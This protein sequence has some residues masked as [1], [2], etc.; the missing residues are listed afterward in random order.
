M[1]ARF[2]DQ[3]GTSLHGTTRRLRWTDIVDVF[4]LKYPQVRVS[5]CLDGVPVVFLVWR[6]AHGVY[7]IQLFDSKKHAYAEVEIRGLQHRAGRV[8]AKEFADEFAKGGSRLR[9]NKRIAELEVE[10]PQFVTF[11]DIPGF[12]NILNWGLFGYDCKWGAGE[13]C[14]TGSGMSVNFVQEFVL[15]EEKHLFDKR[16]EKH[17]Y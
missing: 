11:G 5:R 13:F 15:K 12:G 8:L 1:F 2:L 10:G 16:F 6:D 3:I 14:Q 9:D 4:S 7:T 17:L